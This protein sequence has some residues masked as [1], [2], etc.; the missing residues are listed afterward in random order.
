M[1]AAVN[2]A[3]VHKTL[4]IWVALLAIPFL[5][6][7]FSKIQI[8]AMAVL[9]IGAYLFFSPSQLSFGKGETLA[10]LATLLWAGENVIAKHTLKEL[11]AGIV[12]W[13]RMFFGSVF[14]IIFLALTGQLAGLA[15][16]SLAKFGWLMIVGVI[17]FGYV[18][19]WYSALKRTPA[20]VATSI[21]VLSVPITAILNS[22]FITHKVPFKI[23]I[24]TLTLIVGVLLI[25]QAVQKIV[26][27]AKAKSSGRPSAV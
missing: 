24:P 4:F 2:A 15:A 18:T 6:E 7:K 19:T 3:F 21:L 12:A 23:I 13:G 5:G 25:T 14:L 1:T 27:Y 9:I 11:S 22:I 16:L 26:E 17:L 20:T 10:F 8:A